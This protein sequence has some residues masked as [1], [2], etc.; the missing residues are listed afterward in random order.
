M[1]LEPGHG[2][3]G[4]HGQMRSSTAD[5]E[6][7]IDVLKAAFAEGR[8]SRDEFEERSGRVYRSLTYAELA[9]LTAD[10]P[11]GPLGAMGQHG[12][13]PPG[14][15]QPGLAQ[16][17][18]PVVVPRR[19]VNSLAVAAL[20]CAFIPGFPAAAAVITGVV[21]RRQI[22]ESGER[23]DGVATV[24]IVIGVISLLGFLLFLTAHIR[25]A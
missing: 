11:A 22:R 24:A 18:F 14:M 9:A 8:L 23:G 20:I 2:M 3:P 1:T 25:F 7:A 21:A 15:M 13:A 10:L 6:R 4:W 12:L 16:P 17:P 19:P 5:R